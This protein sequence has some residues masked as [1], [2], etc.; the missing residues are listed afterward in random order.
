MDFLEKVV[1]M[2]S[3]EK[4]YLKC[5]GFNRLRNICNVLTF[6]G[7]VVQIAGCFEGRL[8]VWFH[9]RFMVDS[10]G[11]NASVNMLTNGPNF[12]RV[13]Q[14]LLPPSHAR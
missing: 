3:G 4:S 1:S 13:V 12:P 6:S 7:R 9:K 14:I 5:C 10:Q 11:V 2:L 8:S